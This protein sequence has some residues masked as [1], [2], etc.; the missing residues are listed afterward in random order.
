MR[1]LQEILRLRFEAGRSLREI[2]L[3]ACVALS[4]VQEVLRR[5]V[6]AGLVWPLPTELDEAMLTVRLYPVDPVPRRP[7]PD[8]VALDRTLSRKGMTRKLLWE[9]YAL[10][11]GE[12][13]LSYP[14]F[15]ARWSAFVGP[16]AAV[17]RQVYRPGEK[18]FVDYSGLTAEVIDRHTGQVRK[19]QVFV[20]ALGY[21]HALYAEATWTQA[22]PDWLGSHT[23]A[24]E[25]FDGVPEIVVPDNLKSGVTKPHR[26]EPEIN[27]AYAEWAAHYGVAVLPA[28]VR[29]PDDKAKV[30]NGVLQVQRQILARL[31]GQSFFSLAELN[32]AIRERLE[33]LNDT[34]FQKRE[35]SRRSA[36]IEERQVLRALPECRYSY[37]VWKRAKVH[38]DYHVAHDK[39]MYSVPHTLIGKT[40]DV[41]VGDLVEIY[42][43]GNLVAA[44]TPGYKEGDYSTKQ[45]HRSPAH[46]AVA[47]LSHEKLQQRA[48][49]I[50]EATAA[51]IGAQIHRKVHREQT[52][53][54]AMGIL[55][56]AKDYSP[57]RL[58]AACQR[59]LTLKAYSCRAIT[60]LIRA[61]P[62]PTPKALPKLRHANIR[63]QALFAGEPC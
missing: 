7:E 43:H 2:A 21:S 16:D 36:L 48:L 25:Y 12:A 24:L 27:R 49:A 38:V 18:L 59:A 13:A 5:F 9:G 10:E 39:R 57:E 22:S 3:S 54:S 15:C 20:A 55:R 6:V 61:T 29:T 33:A 1:K 30:E 19:A 32:T 35:G 11:H 47:E 51:V 63:G 62:P 60:D 53:R 31:F 52:L 45:E 46:Q 41:R 42:H 58:E 23:R 50:G 14:Q 56:L 37:G 8:F 28:R 26:Y 44:H 4:T 17:M 34:P 40:V